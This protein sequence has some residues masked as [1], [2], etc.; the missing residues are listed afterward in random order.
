MQTR[1]SCPPDSP[2]GVRPRAAGFSCTRCAS[3]STRASRSARDRSM[4]S[5]SGSAISARTVM[6]GLSALQG[7]WNTMV[8]SRRIGRICLAGIRVMSLPWK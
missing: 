8:M 1:C 5:F 7:S 6:R 2:E 3:A 4:C